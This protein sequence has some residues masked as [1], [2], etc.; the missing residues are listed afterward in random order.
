[1]TGLIAQVYYNGKKWQ[2]T[3]VPACKRQAGAKVGR[4]A[5]IHYLPA[6]T[7]LTLTLKRKQSIRES[8][9]KNLVPGG[10]K[11]RCKLHCVSWKTKG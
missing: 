6:N 2:T 7:K 8:H 9:I 5:C 11:N 4:K 3:A 10:K 1:M